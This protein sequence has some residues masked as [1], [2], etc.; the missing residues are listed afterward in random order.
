MGKPTFKPNPRSRAVWE[1]LDRYLNFCVDYGYRYDPAD[2]YNNKSYPFQ[3]FRKLE[4]GKDPKNM[5]HEDSRR[6]AGYRPDFKRDDRR[7]RGDRYGD[8]RA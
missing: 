3:Q 7:P 2:L 8:R 4:A 6:F 1:D 5:W